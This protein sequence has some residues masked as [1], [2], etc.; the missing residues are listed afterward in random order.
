VSICDKRNQHKGAS[1]CAQA[2]IAVIAAPMSC[3]HDVAALI[4]RHLPA[5]GL[6]VDLSGFKVRVYK[7]LSECPQSVALVHFMRKP[8]EKDEPVKVG[9]DDAVLEA[10]ESVARG[11]EVED[12]YRRFKATAGGRWVPSS[13]SE[14][15][16]LVGILQAVPHA[17]LLAYAELLVRTET[18]LERAIETATPLARPILE[19]LKRLLSSNNHALV[20]AI[21][22]EAAQDWGLH[23]MVPGIAEQLS[24]LSAQARAKLVDQVTDRLL[25]AKAILLPGVIAPFATS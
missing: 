25:S 20:A 6:I 10:F 9:N 7:A 3:A 12:W 1:L 16:R 14:H 19:A 5:R 11:G 21:Q 4:R 18:P 2:D 15:D 22:L 23:S 13:V 24:E 17:I 8:P